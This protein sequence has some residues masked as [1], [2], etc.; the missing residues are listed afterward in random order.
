MSCFAARDWFHY[1]H[2]CFRTPGHI[3]DDYSQNGDRS[4][5]QCHEPWCRRLVVLLRTSR[6]RYC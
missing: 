5:K 4:M 2:G 1:T 6:Q 3:S